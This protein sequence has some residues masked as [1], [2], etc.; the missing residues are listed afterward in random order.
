MSAFSLMS[1]LRWALLTS[2]HSLAALMPRSSMPSSAE[3]IFMLTMLQGARR[4]KV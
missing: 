3:S 4:V 1:M 2:I